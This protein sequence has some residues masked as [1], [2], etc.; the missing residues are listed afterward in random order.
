MAIGIMGRL[1]KM[2][3]MTYTAEELDQ[4]S[5]EKRASI[6]GTE[7]PSRSPVAVVSDVVVAPEPELEGRVLEVDTVIPEGL[8][9]I[10]IYAGAG[11]VS[12]V[13]PYE[14]FVKLVDALAS[15]DD[16]AKKAAL[17]AMDAADDFWTVGDIASDL[18]NKRTALVQY[19]RDIEATVFNLEA[20]A[21]DAITETKTQSDA[22][23]AD[24]RAQIAALEQSIQDEFQATGQRIGELHTQLAANKSAGERE[25]QRISA[26]VFKMTTIEKTYFPTLVT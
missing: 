8:D 17:S 24:M 5:P 23:V 10:D 4:M 15:L 25:G 22:R 7:M 14:K 18:A 16:S 21:N 11:V 2:G 12:S 6:T 1:V 13:Y 3:L 19:Q 20:K 9:V 26:V